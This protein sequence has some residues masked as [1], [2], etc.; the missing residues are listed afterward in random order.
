MQSGDASSVAMI[1]TLQSG[2]AMHPALRNALQTVLSNS[3][4][5]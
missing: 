1:K 4:G 2:I 3:P 5:L